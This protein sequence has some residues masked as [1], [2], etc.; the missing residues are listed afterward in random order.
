MSKACHHYPEDPLAVDVR[1][2]F[3]WRWQEHGTYLSVCGV[4]AVIGTMLVL[5]PPSGHHTIA[6]EIVELIRT[7]YQPSVA[8]A[9]RHDLGVAVPG[10]GKRERGEP[11]ATCNSRSPPRP[12]PTVL[13][14]YR[15]VQRDFQL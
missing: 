5:I 2:R 11:K 7:H 4:F 10:E 6:P 14:G 1:P 15:Q 8:I 9:H 3:K 13:V 12:R